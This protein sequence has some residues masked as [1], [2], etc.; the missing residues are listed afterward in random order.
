MNAWE[1]DSAFA[2][3]PRANDSY[4]HLRSCTCESLSFA[5]VHANGSRYHCG[6]D[7]NGSRYS[8]ASHSR[9]R[10]DDNG[11]YYHLGVPER[12]IN[13]PIGSLFRG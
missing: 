4:S 3:A 1:N 11:S 12:E 2:F 10:P 9:F 13:E 5:F 8:L 6:R 7:G